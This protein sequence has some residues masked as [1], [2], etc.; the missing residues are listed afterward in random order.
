MTWMIE[1]MYVHKPGQ[2]GADTCWNIVKW[3]L[4]PLKSLFCLT[5]WKI[6]IT[7]KHVNTQPNPIFILIFLLAVERRQSVRCLLLWLDSSVF[8]S[9]V[10]STWRHLT[11]WEGCV[12]SDTHARYRLI[13]SVNLFA[14]TV[15]GLFPSYLLTSFDL[16]YWISYSVIT[17][18]YW[19]QITE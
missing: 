6:K 13:F 8:Q 19:R 5:D 14:E 12:P 7:Y 17:E 2:G 1:N 10:T 3:N 15:L 9:T 4:S 11:S 18:N 16:H